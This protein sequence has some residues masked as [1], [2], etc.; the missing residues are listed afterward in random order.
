[1]YPAVHHILADLLKHLKCPQKGVKEAL[2]RRSTSLK[3][4]HKK[5]GRFKKLSNTTA[6]SAVRTQ[7]LVLHF[8]SSVFGVPMTFIC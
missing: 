6:L 4:G 8:S 7:A 5:N 2:D 3:Q 1:M